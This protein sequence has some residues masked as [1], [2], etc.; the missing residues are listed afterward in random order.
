[1]LRLVLEYEDGG[2]QE[3][4]WHGKFTVF[5]DKLMITTS[6]AYFIWLFLAVVSLNNLAWDLRHGTSSP[7]VVKLIW[8][9]VIMILGSFGLLVNLLSY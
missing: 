1:V 6:G 2:I 8:A 5:E 9:L 3:I 7:G 4:I